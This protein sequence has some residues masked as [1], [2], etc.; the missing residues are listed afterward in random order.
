MNQEHFRPTHIR[1]SCL[2]SCHQKEKPL[3]STWRVARFGA[4]RALSRSPSPRAPLSF[5]IWN[6]SHHIQ[7][8][9]QICGRDDE[10]QSHAPPSQWWEPSSNQENRSTNLNHTTLKADPTLTFLFTQLADA[11]EIRLPPPSSAPPRSKLKTGLPSY[12]R[13]VLHITER[14][15]AHE[16]GNTKTRKVKEEASSTGKRHRIPGT[17][18]ALGFSCSSRESVFFKKYIDRDIKGTVLK[19]NPDNSIYW[20]MFS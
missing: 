4:T 17:A 13:V 1:R 2:C 20:V 9:Y 15:E 3:I 10:T 19:T 8:S 12:A 14:E 5:R 6:T 18:A 7:A 11:P 16:E